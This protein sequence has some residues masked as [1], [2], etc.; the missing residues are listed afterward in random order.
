MSNLIPGSGVL[1]HLASCSRRSGFLCRV[2]FLVSIRYYLLHTSCLTLS[3]HFPETGN[4]SIKPWHNVDWR[5]KMDVTEKV[6]AAAEVAKVNIVLW[7]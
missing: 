3:L 6:S 5:G 1:L 4:Y 2:T 7:M